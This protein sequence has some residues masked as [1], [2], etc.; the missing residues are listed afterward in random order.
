MVNKNKQSKGYQG[1]KDFYPWKKSTFL[2]RISNW[3][4]KSK[5]S[6][7]T[8]PHTSGSDS[9]PPSEQNSNDSAKSQDAV[10]ELDAQ[11][12]VMDTGSQ[13]NVAAE[14]A[15]QLPVQSDAVAP[16]NLETENK[17]DIKLTDSSIQLKENSNAEEHVVFEVKGQADT[18][19]VQEINII[20][21]GNATVLDDSCSRKP[22]ASSSDSIMA[23]DILARAFS[24]AIFGEVSMDSNSVPFGT[25]QQS[26]IKVSSE[27]SQN[28]AVLALQGP[29]SSG[30]T[31]QDLHFGGEKD[32]AVKSIL[33][34]GPEG[35][36]DFT[37]SSDSSFSKIKKSG[38]S[39]F[40]VGENSE[41][42]PKEH[43][44]SGAE[45]MDSS[46]PKTENDR[47]TKKTSGSSP[48]EIT[49]T[50]IASPFSPFSPFAQEI[51]NITSAKSPFACIKSPNVPVKRQT[52]PKL[53]RITPIRVKA[54]Y[55]SEDESSS[56]FQA[57]AQNSPLIEDSQLKS[58]FDKSNLERHS[59]S[60]S[61][62]KTPTSSVSGKILSFPS[63]IKE[64]TEKLEQPLIQGLIRQ[65]SA[66]NSQK[67]VETVSS[68]KS[69]E[70]AQS[71]SQKSGTSAESGSLKSD[72]SEQRTSPVVISHP[73]MHSEDANEGFIKPLIS[74]ADVVHSG[75]LSE[76]SLLGLVK[77]SSLGNENLHTIS[78]LTN[79]LT[80]LEDPASQSKAGKRELS[81]DKKSRADDILKTDESEVTLKPSIGEYI[82]QS[83]TSIENMKRIKAL[84]IP[85]SRLSDSDESCSK[86]T[87]GIEKQQK[88]EIN[89]TSTSHEIITACPSTLS[90]DS[91]S[92]Q[93]S[94]LDFS[95]FSEKRDS[96]KEMPRRYS[97]DQFTYLD[98]T[99]VVE[100]VLVEPRPKIGETNEAEPV[101]TDSAVTKLESDKH[102]EISEENKT[103]TLK[104]CKDSN[105]DQKKC[106]RVTEKN[107]SEQVFD[108]STVNK[109]DSDTQAA[110][111]KSII[112]DSKNFKHDR[113]EKTKRTASKFKDTKQVVKSNKGVQNVRANSLSSKTDS[114]SGAD[115]TV[116]LITEADS[117]ETNVLCARVTPR[118]TVSGENKK[119]SVSKKKPSNKTGRG[120]SKAVTGI[121]TKDKQPARK[122]SVNKN[123]KSK[124]GKAE[125]NTGKKDV[126]KSASPTF[127][128]SES[129]SQTGRMAKYEAIDEAVPGPSSSDVGHIVRQDQSS[130]S[131]SSLEA[132]EDEMMWTK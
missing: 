87:P 95:T 102:A 86:H 27:S 112:K 130:S 111:K 51:Q 93:G 39:G 14:A 22:V 34:S 24:S 119:T 85:I 94:Q 121:K 56:A 108:D 92:I 11:A 37:V 83:A 10:T 33:P 46:V 9:K 106:D 21:D 36:I 131:I 26:P 124:F 70:S 57:V 77:G 64:Q 74:D 90:C 132:T 60:E 47:N 18:R 115:E 59:S 96:P 49:E 42:E 12:T 103:N 125:Q 55:L 114:K 20:K 31:S 2:Q 73:V 58:P 23:S 75:I 78:N 65:D 101:Q 79:I 123:N 32:D 129:K 107:R 100:S 118:D 68:Q 66:S 63:N 82:P 98:D 7:K 48:K 16:Q 53:R 126:K 105:S 43:E 4:R 44:N 84:D 45:E 116:K 25:S 91:N 104:T 5:Y 80:A 19:S 76:N 35:K 128:K 109:S 40:L 15:G 28:I 13:R 62:N 122:D 71:M 29:T 1:L 50:S 110:E 69:A 117:A 3:S 17:N 30:S 120:N 99:T 89:T 61:L 8:P 72:I 81:N 113:T 127:N 6:S 67:S 38:S 97:G 88:G 54:H 52:T 41:E